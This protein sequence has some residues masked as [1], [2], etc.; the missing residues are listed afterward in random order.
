MNKEN[1]MQ[2]KH[3]MKIYLNERQ[4]P[5]IRFFHI[6]VLLLVLVQILLS[7]VVDFNDNGTVSSHVFQF[8]GTWAHIVMG[9]I[10]IPLAIIFIVIEFK[11]HGFNHFYPYL[12][13]D[14][15]Q[16]KVDFSQLKQLKVPEPESKGIAAIVQ[17][18]GLGALVL[19]L[20]SGGIWFY[21]WT[22][23]YFYANDAQA[24][25]SFFTGFIITYFF[26]H[27]LMGLWHIF[28]SDGRVK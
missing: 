26:A 10:L 23:G 20:L 13:G 15:Q 12:S 18:L 25:H 1:E 5:A 21:A 14:N 7:S 4:A 22:S 8:Y 27:G 9:L 17:G 28:Y 24:I 19:V 2:I 16:L 3:T 11:N 6:V